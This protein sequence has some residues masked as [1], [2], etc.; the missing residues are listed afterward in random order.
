MKLRELFR[1]PPHWART[2]AG[3]RLARLDR[4]TVLDYADEAAAG[5]WKALEAYRR[6]PESYLLV[7]AEHGLQT[8]LGAVDALRDRT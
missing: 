8:L 1:V 3:R 4:G 5:V 6:D 2:K 7:D